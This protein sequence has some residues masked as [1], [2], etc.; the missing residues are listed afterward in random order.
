[1]PGASCRELFE[2]VKELLDGS[3]PG[4]F[5]H[6]L[7]HGVGLYPHE[8]PNLNPHWDHTFAEG[9]FFTVE[10]GLYEEELKGGL[11]LE[12]NYVV[13]AGGVKKLTWFPLDL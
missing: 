8:Q 4:S 11:R 10:P 13:V 7:G 2:E 9:D 6:H 5:F 12:E 3:W 1:M